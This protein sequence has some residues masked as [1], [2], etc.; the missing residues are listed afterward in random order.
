MGYESPGSFFPNGMLGNIYLTSVAQNDKGVINISGLEEELE[1]LLAPQILCNLMLPALYADDIYDYFTVICKSACDGSLFEIRMTS[2][3]V[4]IEHE[5]GLTSSLFKQL[6]VKYSWKL[7][8]L[9]GT[10]NQH[11]FAIFF[12]VNVY[13]CMRGNKT[14]KKYQMYP[15]SVDEYLNVGVKER[16]DGEDACEFMLDFL[17]GNI[18]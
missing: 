15:P 1:R 8:K 17:G 6:M 16:Y 10:V 4:D 13:T 5:F 3:R 14:S 7:L 12:M 11:L 9:R 2:S 18:K